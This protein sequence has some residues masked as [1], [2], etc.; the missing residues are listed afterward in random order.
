MNNS[1]RFPDFGKSNGVSIFELVS[2]PTKITGVHYIQ[3]RKLMQ[4]IVFFILFYI[5][6][7][8]TGFCN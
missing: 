5:I 1:S 8:G 7:S 3:V 6:K 2:I 4:G